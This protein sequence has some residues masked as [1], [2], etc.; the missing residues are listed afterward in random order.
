MTT[1]H[2]KGNLIGRDLIF[3][4]WT[5]VGFLTEKVYTVGQSV[6]DLLGLRSWKIILMACKQTVCNLSGRF[7]VRNSCLCF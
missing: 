3:S 4:A 2:T 1:H 6:G 5:G 7:D